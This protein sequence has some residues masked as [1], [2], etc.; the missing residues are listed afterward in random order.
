MKPV[1]KIAIALS[2]IAFL[3]VA[4]AAV[5]I[6]LFLS[7]P[8]VVAEAG[9]T[10]EIE[11]GAGFGEISRQLEQAGIVSSADLLRF[12]ARLTGKAGTIQAGEYRIDSGTTPIELLQQ[13]TSGGVALYSF[14]VIE[15]WNREPRARRL[16]ERERD[17]SRHGADGR[18]RREHG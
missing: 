17:Q 11:P 9:T 16:G 3:V 6:K 18:H 14:T 5:R 13:F 8:L 1:K 15:G 12:Y 10:F 4:V 7:T 2:V